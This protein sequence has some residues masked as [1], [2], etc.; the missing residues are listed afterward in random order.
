MAPSTVSHGL[1]GYG[2]NQKP[3]SEHPQVEITCPHCGGASHWNLLQTL[4]QCSYCGS[5]LFWPYPEGEPDYLVAESQIRKESDLIDVLAM[6]DAMREAS[7]RRG[8]MNSGR[9]DPDTDI[10]FDLGSGF[11]DTDIYEIKRD[12][13]PLFRLLK[14]FCVYVPYQLVNSLLAFHVLGRISGEL[15]AV[16]SLFFLSEA[17]VPGYS[18][19]WNF[20]D[21]GLQLS[22]QNLKPLTAGKWKEPFLATGAPTNEIE[23]LVRQWTSYRK[24]IEPDIQPICFR[25]KALE[26]LRWW[27][28][29]PYYFV[30]AQTPD[31]VRWFLVDGQFGTI[32]GMPDSLEVGR[33]VRGDWK[34][35]DLREVRALDVKVVPFRCPN[36]GW[37]VKLQK[38]DYQLCGNCTRLMA[39]GED[40][41]A[42]QPYRIL[43]PEQLHWWPKNHRGPKVWLP[44][45][46]VQPSILFEKK[47]FDDFTQL[48]AYLLPGVKIDGEYS[49]FFIPAHDCWTVAKYDLWSFQLGASLNEFPASPE[50][51]V[52][53]DSMNGSDAIIPVKI[54]KKLPATLFPEVMPMFM[55]SRVQVRMNT[56]LINR[57]AKA[58]VLISDQEL[59]YVPAPVFEAT[60]RDPKVQGPK[61]MIDWL[62]LKDGN[63]PPVLQRTV[64]RWKALSDE[65]REDK[66]KSRGRWL[67]SPFN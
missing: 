64:R 58:A 44:F 35:L 11:T 1:K 3:E 21:K 7:K 17:I 20:R 40:G 48:L 51:S 66:P 56:I 53:L 47:R 41:M 31:G 12:R 37:D 19:D 23:K 32:A 4:N 54:S 61:S 59:V 49:H 10:S 42:V 18:E 52:L 8:R 15:K 26:S 6:Y 57:L 24:L 33:I 13:L 30:N 55:P 45:W 62:P 14:S 16:R 9:A 5:L 65:P 39:V 63:W 38:G 50:K 60:G 34:K 22:K 2:L 29:R 36:C 28:Y 27:V 25:G 43:L 46:R 67:T